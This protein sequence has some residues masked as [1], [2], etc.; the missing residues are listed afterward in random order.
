MTSSRLSLAAAFALVVAAV[1]G[2]ADTSGAR[3]DSAPTARDQS[4]TAKRQLGIDMDFYTYP[5]YNVAPGAAA[6]VAYVQSLGA[7]A[8]SVSFPYFVSGP[9]AKSVH[10]NAATPTPAQ[11]AIIAKDAEDAGLYFSIRP[12]LDQRTLGK[13]GRVYWKPVDLPALFASYEKFLRPYAQMAQHYHIQAI[14]IGAEF[15]EFYNSPQWGKL[16]SYLRRY[17]HGTLAYSNNWDVRFT[18][19]V[20]SGGVVQLL[21]AY[22]IMKLNDNASPRTLTASWDAYLR[23]YPGSTVLSEVGIA[24]LSGAY[25]APYNASP[26]GK[27]LKPYI[28]ER[29]FTAA[30]DA[31]A[32]SRDGGIYFWVV[33]VGQPLN[34]PPTESDPAAWVDGPGATA[35]TACFKHL[36]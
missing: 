36:R 11:L 26:N 15:D 28:Q 18:R 19:R 1:V 16:A 8:L 27:P 3:A 22:P 34:V 23:R 17:Y 31:V 14:I 32:N 20:K 24:A 4:A 10:G 25:R 9:K 33:N 12:L 6:D 35:V 2:C 21:D 30:C 29:W 7:N 5:G 13:G